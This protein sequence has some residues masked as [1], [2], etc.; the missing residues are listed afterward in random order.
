[1]LPLGNPITDHEPGAADIDARC[2]ELGTLAGV[3][4]SNTCRVA[5]AMVTKPPVLEKQA[6]FS[7]AKD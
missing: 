3:R 2:Q 5:P 6:L 7:R 1:M 4:R